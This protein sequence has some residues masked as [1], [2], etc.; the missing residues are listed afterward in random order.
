MDLKWSVLPWKSESIDLFTAYII[1][2][3]QTHSFNKQKPT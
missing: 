3:L 1:K 2:K